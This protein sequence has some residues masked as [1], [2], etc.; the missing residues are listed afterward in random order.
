MEESQPPAQS[1]L[2]HLRS[3]LLP[4]GHQFW[5]APGVTIIPHDSHSSPFIGD[6]IVDLFSDNLRRY[7]AGEPLRNLID[8]QRGY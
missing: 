6:N 2:P 4:L 8:R 3:L 7:I 5:D 1:F